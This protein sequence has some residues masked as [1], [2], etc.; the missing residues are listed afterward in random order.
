MFKTAQYS[1]LA[2][3]YIRWMLLKRFYELEH[4]YR[5]VSDRIA[6]SVGVTDIVPLLQHRTRIVV[7]AREIL[8]KMNLPEPHW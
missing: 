5:Q 1:N 4:E 3:I 2:Q 8:N 6:K 7:E